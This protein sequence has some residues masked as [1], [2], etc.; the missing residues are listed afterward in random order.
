MTAV[1]CDAIGG[2]MERVSGIGGLFFRS[3]DPEMMAEW[4]EK[5]L[6]VK[7][8]PATYDEEPWRQDAGPTVFAPFGQDS[9]L[10]GD[11]SRMWMINF[12]VYDLDKMVEQLRAGGVDVDVDKETYP[13]GR[14]A[15][16]NDPEGNPVQLWEPAEPGGTSS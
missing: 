10:F 1:S 7:C 14:F 11:P 12:R 4:Y 3:A 5:H 13:N 9:G 6:G 15:S 2:V 8:V 16:L